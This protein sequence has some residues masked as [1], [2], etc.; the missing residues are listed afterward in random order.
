MD[1][2][3]RALAEALVQRRDKVLDLARRTPP[4]AV[5]AA[6]GRPAGSARARRACPESRREVPA[7][8]RAHARSRRRPARSGH[9]APS[10]AA[11]PR[12]A[13]AATRPGTGCRP[14]GTPPRTRV[15]RAFVRTST[16][17]SS[18]GKPAVVQLPHVRDDAQRRARRP[19][20]GRPEP[21]A[22]ASSPSRRAAARV[23]SRARAPAASTGS[24][25]RAARRV[26]AGSA[27]AAR[28][29]TGRSR[30]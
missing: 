7:E 9:V 14:R 15:V 21:S 10:A 25:A 18:S 19:A 4:R 23:G 13:R 12:R 3:A 22:R 2:A 26:R 6:P 27:A 29:A 30:P 1:A 8:R 24:S 5:R 11:A 28:A 20:P 17:I 16:A